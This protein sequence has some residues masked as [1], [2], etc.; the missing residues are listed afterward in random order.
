MTVIKVWVKKSGVLSP[1]SWDRKSCQ[2]ILTV[3]CA[4][5][6]RGRDDTSS[7]LPLHG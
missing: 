7:Q 6:K 4:L 5:E 1:D 3:P 2:M